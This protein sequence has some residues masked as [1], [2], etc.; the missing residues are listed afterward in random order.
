MTWKT[1]L[2]HFPIMGLDDQRKK[3]AKQFYL[4]NGTSLWNREY[5]IFP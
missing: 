4:D 1:H 3:K 2:L 5:E